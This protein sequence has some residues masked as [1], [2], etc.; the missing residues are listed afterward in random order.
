MAFAEC[1]AI[2]PNKKE[3]EMDKCPN[4]GG[5][6]G[7]EWK[8]YGN[9][10]TYQLDFGGSLEMRE[11]VHVENKTKTPVYCRCVNCGKRFKINDV[12]K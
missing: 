12:M 5:V 11:V 4:C 7:V 2:C 8:D 6:D 3:D 10:Y 9:I 1:W